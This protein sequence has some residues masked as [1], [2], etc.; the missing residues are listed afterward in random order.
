[1]CVYVDVGCVWFVCMQRA[2]SILYFVLL[3]DL[4]CLIY[5][6]PYTRRGHASSL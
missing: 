1:M 6:A 2:L 4:P 5:N 3:Q